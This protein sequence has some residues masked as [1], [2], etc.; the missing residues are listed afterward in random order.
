MR[1]FHKIFLC[2]LLIFGISFQIAG[3]LLINYAYDSTIEQQKKYAYQ[4]FQYNKYILQSIL[5]SEQNFRKEKA[6]EL[7][8]TEK[9]T[10]PI[11]LYGADNE[12]IFTNIETQLHVPDFNDKEDQNIS[13]W[14]TQ[15]NG[16][17]SIFVYD[18]IQQ[19]ESTVYLITQ[20]DIRSVVDT[21]RNMIKF[22][23]KI[24]LIILCIALPIILLLTGLITHSIK[25]VSRA[26]KRIAE[27]SYS[28]RI[29]AAG[30]DEIGELADNFNQMAERI[31]E[32]ITELYDAARAKE[33]FV[34]N[35]SHEL[36]TPLTSVIGYADL[37]YQKE[38]PRE[39]VKDAAEYILNEGMRLEALSL[40]LMDLFVLGK[41]DF[42]LERVSVKEL[43][44]NLIQGIE[45]ICQKYGIE[46]HINIEEEYIG[47]D[48]DL[49]KT[50]I[51]NLIDNAGKADCR[52]IWITG[53]TRE[54]GYQIQIKDNGRGIPEEEV[55]R[56]TEAFYMV[57]K[58]RARKQH[59]AGLGL[60]LVSKIVE[61]HNARIKINSDG[62]T[63]TVIN[64]VFCLQ[65][66]DLDDE[67][68]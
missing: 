50:M 19:G 3:Y 2:F 5:H 38:L 48:Y 61:I 11:A 29:D 18:C 15:E 34:A 43:F 64:I 54:G 23:Q 32:K 13:Y 27:G 39:Q 24:Y 46:L 52:D 51:L 58:S 36:K 63:G 28:E 42:L 30:K 47:A 41:Q 14:I 49:F 44:Q 53:I 6:A 67:I 8:G 12:C 65:E 31:E 26:A 25:N 35:F 22:F 57:D 1:L 68:I 9:F 17:S 10:V 56:I 16:E 45:P 62:K 4:E 33:D 66:G 21:Q 37:M 60:A 59:G 20:T 7:T 55:G 40:K